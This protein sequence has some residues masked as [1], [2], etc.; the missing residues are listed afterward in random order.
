MFVSRHR[1]ILKTCGRTTLLAAM[2]PLLSLV[3]E[4]CH[5]EVVVSVHLI[6]LQVLFHVH[7]LAI[8]NIYPVEIKNS[9]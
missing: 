7:V 5:L 1:I 6:L 2:K 9:V 4:Q 3:K 8:L